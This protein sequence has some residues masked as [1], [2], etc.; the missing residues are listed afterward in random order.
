MVQQPLF[1][2]FYRFGMDAVIV[3]GSG[4]PHPLRGFMRNNYLNGLISLVSDISA[5][6]LQV[7]HLK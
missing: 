5:F 1:Y 2:F 6:K 7:D 4:I 3:V